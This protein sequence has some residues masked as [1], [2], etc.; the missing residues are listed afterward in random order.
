MMQKDKLE[1]GSLFHVRSLSRVSVRSLE[2]IT[3]YDFHSLHHEH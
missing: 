1:I 3:D 2:K